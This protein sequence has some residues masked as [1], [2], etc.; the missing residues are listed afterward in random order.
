MR[1]ASETRT[2]RLNKLWKKIT[3]ATL[4]LPGATRSA[5]IT[6]EAGAGD[7]MGAITQH[8]LR[9]SL[10]LNQHPLRDLP[11]P[12]I[13]FIVNEI[14]IAE[15]T[16]FR[17]ESGPGQHSL[18]LAPWPLVTKRVLTLNPSIVGVAWPLPTR[19]RE[20]APYAFAIA[21]RGEHD[22]WTA[23]MKQG[24]DWMCDSFALRPLQSTRRQ[25]A[26]L[27]WTTCLYYS[28]AGSIP[29]PTPL[30]YRGPCGSSIFSLSRLRSL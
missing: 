12:L 5:Y 20:I 18:L 19:R 7:V 17:S 24:L 16:F 30:S 28:D 25:T 8:R 4:R 15:A 10:S 22:R 23:H 29:K 6:A 3:R 26:A 14:S 13:A 21:R 2:A 27:H 1:C 9:L 11:A